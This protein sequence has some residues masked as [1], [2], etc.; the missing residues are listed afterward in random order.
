MLKCTVITGDGNV[1]QE[2]S[3][4]YFKTQKPNNVSRAM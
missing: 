3:G 4:K 2:I 1:F